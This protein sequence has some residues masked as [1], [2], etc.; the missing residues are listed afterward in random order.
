[1]RTC[2]H[3]VILCIVKSLTTLTNSA[4]VISPT[5]KLYGW[6]RENLYLRRTSTFLYP[7]RTTPPPRFWMYFAKEKKSRLLQNQHQHST[8]I[9]RI[10]TNAKNQFRSKDQEVFSFWGFTDNLP[11]RLYISDIAKMLNNATIGSHTAGTT[12][13]EVRVSDSRKSE[14]NNLD[15]KVLK[16]YLKAITTN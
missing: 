13:Q 7:G 9:S 11:Q 10:Q 4:I 1:M 16:I 12:H 3:W 14:S 5:A 2:D 6:R 8:L 15:R